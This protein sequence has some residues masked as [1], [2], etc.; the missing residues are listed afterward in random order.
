VKLHSIRRTADLRVTPRDCELK[1]APKQAPKKVALRSII[2]PSATFALVFFSVAYALNSFTIASLY[3]SIP[4]ELGGGVSGL[5]INTSSFYIGNGVFLVPGGMMAAKLGAKKTI[6]FGTLLFSIAVSVTSISS[7]LYQLVLLRLVVGAGMAIIL[8]PSFVLATRYFRAGSEGVAVGLMNAFYGI[9]GVIGLSLWAVLGQL[10]G[11]RASLVLSGTI[12]L[13]ST[14]LLLLTVPRDARSPEF[15]PRFS[16]FRS[17]ILNRSL[18]LYG[19]VF[20][21]LTVGTGLFGYFVV[22]YLHDNLGIA[23]GTAGLVGSLW[24]VFVLMISPLAGRAYQRIKDPKKFIFLAVTIL[25]IGIALPASGSVFAT[26]VGAALVGLA[27]GSSYTIGTSVIKDITRRESHEEYES[28]AINW[29]NTISYAGFWAPLL[30]SYVAT[31]LGYGAGWLIGAV[32]T[33]V[34]VIP[35]LYMKA[36]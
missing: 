11:W 5:A 20:V 3:P 4:S 24:L 17:L 21:S 31:T 10:I 35:L 25:S 8:G 22:L 9:G 23:T 18:I 28:M 19:L 1:S 6:V 12:G 36:R 15:R 30:F 7:A 29:V 26:V 34:W 2:N 33:F 16:D 32:V 14:L 13:I 27:A